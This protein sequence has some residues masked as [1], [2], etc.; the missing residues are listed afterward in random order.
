MAGFKKLFKKFLGFEEE[1]ENE[2]TYEEF[3]EPEE[4]INNLKI[5]E[6]K[7]PNEITLFPKTFADACEVVEQI[8]IGNIVTINM[9]D[10]DIPIVKKVFLQSVQN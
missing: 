2:V 4:V 5:N 3:E 7:Q 10:V 9:N 1:T 8:E 6:V